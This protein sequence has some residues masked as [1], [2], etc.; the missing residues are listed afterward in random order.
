MLGFSLYF[1]NDTKVAEK[2]KMYQGY[3]ILFTSLHY[4]S[5]N[6]IYKEFLELYHKSKDLNFDI[7]VDVNNKTLKEHPELIDMGL[8]LRLD[9]GFTVYEI[10]SLSE[11]T[12]FAINASTVDNNFLKNLNDNQVKMEN[13]VGW[14]N[15]YPFNFTGIGK[16]FFEEQ[17]KLIKKYNM[18]TAAFVPGNHKLRGPVYKGLPTLEDHR[19]KNPY[20]SLV[21]LKRAYN[22]DICLI[23]EAVKENDEAYIKKFF[24]DN[25]FC[26]PSILDKTYEDLKEIEV[27][28]DVSDYIVRN[29][30]IKTDIVPKSCQ[31]IHRGDILICNNL[32][33]RYAG[34]IEIAR[35]DLGA[36][37][38]RNVIGR[39]EREYL[40]LLDYIEGGDK[41]E[42]NRK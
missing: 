36:L 8:I 13:I 19:Y 23:A 10:I 39:V 9:F 7:C 40:E 25:I 21:E 37:E 3:D 32:S 17:N 20:V 18:K 12:R 30:R 6:Q 5:S 29:N 11:K 42:F 4:P 27:R 2:V 1:E 15:Y 34:E 22:I 28:P 33:G 35:K 24:I 41:I 14:H 31:Y 26:L 16:D 38:D